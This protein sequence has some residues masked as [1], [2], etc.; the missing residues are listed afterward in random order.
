MDGKNGQRC[1]K[2]ATNPCPEIM[3]RGLCV[4]PLFQRGAAAGKRRNFPT[5]RANRHFLCKPGACL[6][7]MAERAYLP[8]VLTRQAVLRSPVNTLPCPAG[9]GRK[10]AGGTVTYNTAPQGTGGDDWIIS[11]LGF[12]I[13]RPA[14]EGQEWGNLSLSPRFLQ[15]PCGERTGI[16][17]AFCLKEVA[18]TAG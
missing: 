1:R 11:N 12:I 10:G 9:K 15:L 18:K 4:F 16:L 5:A 14:G 17:V 2:R 13:S 7:K 6:W 8:S 3:G